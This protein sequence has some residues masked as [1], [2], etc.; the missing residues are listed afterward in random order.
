MLIPI[1]GLVYPVPA[2]PYNVFPYLVVFAIAA[3]A[4]AAWVIGR[5]HPEA[6]ARAGAVLA[7]AEVETGDDHSTVDPRV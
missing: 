1:Y 3:S 4:T 2:A 5:R 7:A 6:L